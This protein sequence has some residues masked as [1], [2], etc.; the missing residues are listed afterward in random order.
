M[1][2]M[3]GVSIFNEIMDK[4][5]PALNWNSAIIIALLNDNIIKCKRP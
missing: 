1:G 3:W 5:E 2:A 4:I